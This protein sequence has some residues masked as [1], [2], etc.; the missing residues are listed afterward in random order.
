VNRQSIRFRLTAWYA[1]ILALTFAAVGIGV[2]LAIRDSINDTVDKDLRSRLQ[3][4]R[5]SFQRQ[6]PGT[7]TPL[8]E[9]INNAALAPAGT[10][11]R[12]ADSN[13]RW[14]Y[15]S[16]GT[17]VWGVAPPDIAGLPKRG[18]V[19][20]V[21]QKGKSVRVLSAAIPAGIVQIGIATDEFGEMLD[22]F[23]WTALLASPLLLILASAGGYWMSRHALAPVERIARTAD[24]IEAQNL[25]KRLPLLGTGDELDHLSKT[26]NAMFGRLEDSF[27]RITQFT[28]DASHEL[29][30]PV[31]I[32][33]TTA[34]VTRRKPRTGK[35]YEA[36]LDRILAESERTT[37]LIEDLMLLARADAHVEET[38][39]EPV[40]LAE[41]VR[42]ACAEARVLAEDR[43]I[44]LKEDEL[45]PCTVSGD[46]HALRRLV[47]I[48]LDNAIKYSKPRGEVSLHLKVCRPDGRPMAV[49]E[50]R[51]NG[52]G[53]AAEDLPH[54]FERFYRASKDRSR[55]IGGVGLGLSIAQ[56]IAQRQGGEIQVEST[57]GAG[58]IARVVLP[59]L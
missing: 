56:T 49:L 40:A 43:G 18:R 11:F 36:A 41:L 19:E 4:M 53:I 50:V 35:E 59:A 57:A 45:N 47:L 12:V 26:L 48:L 46:C 27:R 54:I 8:K 42:A 16:P 29:R 22:A 9:W 20:T 23:T 31:A 39:P 2:W 1:A 15:Q 7:A 14:L 34:E 55:K 10:R 37:G 51:D 25:S 6:A 28:A 13:G 52:I 33:R 17:E 38:T 44:G 24:E 30:T 21:L 32:I 3:A 58:S 5:D